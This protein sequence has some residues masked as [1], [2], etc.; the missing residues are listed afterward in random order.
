MAQDQEQQNPINPTDPRSNF[1]RTV[2]ENQG[3][4]STD[5]PTLRA[6][7]LSYRALRMWLGPAMMVARCSISRATLFTTT[8]YSVL[9]EATFPT[10]SEKRTKGAEVDCLIESLYSDVTQKPANLS[11]SVFSEVVQS[12]NTDPEC[13]ATDIKEELRVDDDEVQQAAIRILQDKLAV[14]RPTNQVNSTSHK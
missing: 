12:G 11:D 13:L 8:Q 2:P 9:S 5:P 6:F 14:M 4:R 1:F 10:F 3:S 7:C